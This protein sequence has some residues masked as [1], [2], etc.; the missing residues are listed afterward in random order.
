MSLPQT[1]GH[2]TN[3]HVNN[4]NGTPRVSSDYEPTNW[5]E[6]T[7]RPRWHD[8]EPRFVHSVKWVDGDGLEHLHIVRTDALDEVL[9]EVRMLQQFISIC[10]EQ[11][12]EDHAT[13]TSGESPEGWCSIHNAKMQ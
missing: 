7:P 6:W 2:L 1:D 13:S 12:Q 8:R 11:A 3:G 10:R 9:Y 5:Q 4:V